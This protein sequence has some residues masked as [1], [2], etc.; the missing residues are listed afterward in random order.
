MIAGILLALQVGA[1]TPGNL[2]VRHAEAVRTVP[3]IS[4]LSGPYLRA[5]LLAIALGGTAG[6]VPQGRYAI[7]LGDSRIGRTEGVPFVRINGNVVQ[8]VLP[9]RRSGQT[10]LVP[11]QLAASA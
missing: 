11:F 3:R 10:F 8:L 5:D 9:P 7:T 2:V 1:A 6:L 4:T